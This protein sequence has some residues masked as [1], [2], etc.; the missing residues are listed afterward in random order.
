MTTSSTGGGER[1][2]AVPWSTVLPLAVVLA[3]TASFW[4][5]ALRTSAGAIER[6]STPSASWVRESTLLLPVFVLAVLGALTWA[7]RSF[8]RDLGRFRDVGCL[9]LLVAALGSVVGA[10]QMT[11]SSAYDY[12]LQVHQTA[13]MASMQSS[14]ASDCQSAVRHATMIL[15]VRVVVV[16]ALLL[17][18]TNVVAVVWVLAL[19]GWR[20][21]LTSEPTG[22]PGRDGALGRTHLRRTLLVWGLAG[23]AAIHVAV[24]PEHLA[25]WKVAGVF[26]V[27]LALVEL[28]LSALAAVRRDAV[29][30]LACIAASVGPLLLWLTSRTVGLPLV[31]GHG[32]VEAVG[33]AD[34]AAC[35]LEVITLLAA[36]SLLGA[37]TASTQRAPSVQGVRF[38]VVSVIA[39]TALG[40]GGTELG[41]ASLA[42]D[43]QGAMGH[44]APA[45]PGGE[46]PPAGPLNRARD[47]G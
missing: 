21:R 43:W 3:L 6:T 24:V 9:A 46:A 38:A 44:G 35:V 20:L 40:L 29:V 30:H 25:E 10:A 4:T 39:L 15:Q 12:R 28:G 5:V 45:A 23:S 31:P 37:R 11:L 33:L 13:T 47:P 2:S 22:D 14:C 26:F 1:P 17:L 42:A 32:E 16:G 8:G 18:V 34:V 36:L 27:L 7:Q 41:W 19:R